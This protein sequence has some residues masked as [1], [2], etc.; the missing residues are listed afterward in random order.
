MKLLQI[1]GILLFVGGLRAQTTGIDI[2]FPVEKYRL[3]NGLTVLLFQDRSAP[4]VSYH[5]WFRVGSKDE[6]LGQTGL[7]HLFE[8]MMFKGSK[9][10]PGNAF[11]EI[12]LANGITN[13]AFTTRD[14]TGYYENLPSTKL[15]KVM[16]VEADR[17]RNLLIDESMLRSEIEVV[18]EERR[19]RVDNNPS[20]Q[21]FEAMM[22]NLYR[23]HPYRWPVIGSMEDL[24]S[25]QVKDCIDFYNRF[26]SPSNAVLVIGGDID[27]AKTKKWI[28]KYYAPIKAFAADRRSLPMEPAQESPR[29]TRIYLDLKSPRL[30]LAYLAPKVG[31]RDS[32]A[33][34]VL[35]NVLS[36]GASS[37]LRLN[38]EYKKQWVSDVYAY[39][40]A[41]MD[42]GMFAF[43]ADVKKA[44]DI[45][46]VG[47]AIEQ[48]IARIQEQG[49][50]E[51]EL[52]KAVHQIQAGY[53]RGLQTIADKT[54]AL[55]LNEVMLG[56]HEYL[57]TDLQRYD[58][59]RSED[60]QKA[61]ARYLNKKSQVRIEAL[62][63]KGEK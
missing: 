33:L 8:H 15:Q 19:L 37:R 50:E 59:V 40:M 14:Y 3:A 55:A 38:L 51:K 39:Y 61:A 16:A 11:E 35:A 47:V 17:M 4:L 21:L 43:Y 56:S 13:N 34:D 36:E 23:V 53:V 2:R 28:E 32:Y 7:A 10:F 30:A 49:I 5:T 54:H 29:K 48:E 62:P 44:K 12:L 25:L 52:R 63:K 22:S 42:S 57:F 26:Y 27:V 20:G 9:N 46:R 45:Q 60:V 1:F 6:N 18:K 58:Q 41:N 24:N 31:S